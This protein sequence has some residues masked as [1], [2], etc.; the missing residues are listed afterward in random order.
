MTERECVKCRLLLPPEAFLRHNGS[1]DG[2][3]TRCRECELRRKREYMERRAKEKQGAD[4]PFI[5]EGGQ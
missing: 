3:T 4:T 1:P 2:L 5:V